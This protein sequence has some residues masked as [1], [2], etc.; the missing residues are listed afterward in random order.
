[1]RGLTLHASFRGCAV[2]LLRAFLDPVLDREKQTQRAC[3]SGISLEGAR[4]AS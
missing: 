3:R 4:K 1:M 2:L